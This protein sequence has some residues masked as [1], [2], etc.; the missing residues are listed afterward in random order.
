LT[1]RQPGATGLPNSTDRKFGAR[2]ESAHTNRE[3]R[4]NP[5]KRDR[6]AI[7]RERHLSGC[8]KTAIVTLV[9]RPQLD[10]A[11]AICMHRLISVKN[12]AVLP[13]T[14]IPALIIEQPAKSGFRS[15]QHVVP[16]Y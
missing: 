14:P 10:D 8:H 15:L 3:L 1:G 16:E 5:S 13:K 2:P 11:E 6:A 12:V 7:K 4:P 9:R